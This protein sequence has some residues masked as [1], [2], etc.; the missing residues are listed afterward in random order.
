M[1][2]A[3][4]T[5]TATVATRY[6]MFLLTAERGEAK[7]VGVVLTRGFY[8]MAVLRKMF[9]FKYRYSKLKVR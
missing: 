8:K 1:V 2:N 6:V 3:K 7:C 4:A 5:H 9:F